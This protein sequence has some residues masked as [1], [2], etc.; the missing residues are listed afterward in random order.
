[1][2][3]IGLEG[4]GFIAYSDLGFSFRA[5]GRECGGGEGEELGGS[6]ICGG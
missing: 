1:M 3:E 4:P 2:P 5:A 6:S